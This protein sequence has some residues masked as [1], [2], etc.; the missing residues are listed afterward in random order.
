M[1]ADFREAT[2]FCALLCRGEMLNMLFEADLFTQFRTDFMF[3]T[4][5]TG[6]FADPLAP[7]LRIQPCG[8]AWK[9][10]IPISI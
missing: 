3:G 10:S 7:K 8:V 2:A 4:G 1:H 6:T 9:S 5:T